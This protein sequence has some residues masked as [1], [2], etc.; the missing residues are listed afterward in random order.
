MESAAA[1]PATA[2][3]FSSHSGIRSSSVAQDLTTFG[4][5]GSLCFIAFGIQTT[6]LL[7][8][9]FAMP[10]RKTSAKALSKASCDQPSPSANPARPARNSPGT[11]VVCGPVIRYSHSP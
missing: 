8:S 6:L 9:A 3:P 4:D 2:S 7:Q 5:A 1:M 11:E 10:S